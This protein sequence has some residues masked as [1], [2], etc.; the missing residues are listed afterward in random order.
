MNF[1]SIPSIKVKDDGTFDIEVGINHLL[2]KSEIENI[3]KAGL[4][5]NKLPFHWQTVSLPSF[6][7][8]GEPHVASARRID[9]DENIVRDLFRIVEKEC[10]DNDLTDDDRKDLANAWDKVT[11]ELSSF[12]EDAEMICFHNFDIRDLSGEKV[13]ILRYKVVD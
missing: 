13:L 3:L 7:Y 5:Q 11:D 10:V 8:D 2:E 4:S 1:D 9:V 6:L 12:H